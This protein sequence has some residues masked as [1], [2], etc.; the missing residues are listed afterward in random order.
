MDSWTN[1]FAN[2][3]DAINTFR[4]QVLTFVAFRSTRYSS[5]TG[6]MRC[7][8]RLATGDSNAR[9]RIFSDR[10]IGAKITIGF[11]FGFGC[12]LAIVAVISLIS[13]FEFG[14]VQFD[15]T[16][17]ARKLTNGETVT[18]IDREFVA[19]RRYIGEVSN[20][21]RENF[22]ATATTRGS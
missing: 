17:Y 21:M 7:S 5:L 15:F 1:A 18:D 14:R 13:Y 20:N 6:S 12:V 11:G 4:E 16:D 8:I 9:S 3:E 10:R 22:A 2:S 19:Y